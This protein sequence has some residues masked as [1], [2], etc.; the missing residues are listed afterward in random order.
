MA[1]LP[2]IIQEIIFANKIDDN[3]VLIRSSTDK[4]PYFAVGFKSEKANHKFRYIWLY[5]VRAKGKAE[6][7][8]CMIAKRR[9][10]LVVCYDCH[11]AIH[12]K[13][14]RLTASSSID[15][16]PDALRGASPVLGGDCANL[17]QT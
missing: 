6:W 7:E 9:K 10:T 4:P 16:E 5:K 3:G 1:D 2:L 13:T 14:K 17:P 12:G 8:R 15:G 11:L